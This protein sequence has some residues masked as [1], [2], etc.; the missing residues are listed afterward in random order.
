[1]KAA[2]VALGL[3]A[4]AAAPSAESLIPGGAD[5]SFQVSGSEW[6]TTAFPF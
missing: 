6:R 1:M 5:Y 2:A 4:V 3:S